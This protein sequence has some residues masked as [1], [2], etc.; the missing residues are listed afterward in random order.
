MLLDA[1]NSRSLKHFETCFDWTRREKRN[2]E[3]VATAFILIDFRPSGG[4]E[5]FHWRLGRKG[6]FELLQKR[7]FFDESTK[8]STSRCDPGKEF[9]MLSDADKLKAHC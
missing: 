1:D 5:I 7:N 8:L 3:D 6:V 9:E 2:L 4:S